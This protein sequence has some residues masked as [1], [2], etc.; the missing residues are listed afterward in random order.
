[1]SVKA[2]RVQ[3]IKPFNQAD[4]VVTW[5]ELGEVLRNVRYAASKIAN[6]AIQRLYSWEGFSQRYKEENGSYPVTKEHH[7]EWY[8]NYWYTEARRLF[9][10]VAAQ[11]INQ[12][13]RH[14]EKVW[15]SRKSEVLKLRQSVPSFK[16]DFPIC[17]HNKDGYSVKKIDNN[18]IVA[19]TLLSREHERS[20][21]SFIVKAGERSKQVIL[22]R[23]I[24]G[25]YKRGAMQIISDRKK[26][27]YCIIPY[28]FTPECDVKLDETKIMGVDLGIANAAYW[29]FSDSFKRGKIEGKEIEVFRKRI[30]ERRKSIQNQGK[31]C[32]DGRIGHGRKRRLE[33]IEVLQN[34]E[35]NFRA[36]TNHR[37]SR[38]I[39]E[40]AVRNNCGMI[41][42]EDLTSVNE[43]S[44]FLKNW[45]YYDL[46]QKIAEKAEEFNIRVVKINPEYTS[47]RCSKCG[48]IDKY[49]R[50]DQ[51]T[52]VC[53][54]CGYGSLYHCFN[55][56]KD[57]L[58]SG[59]C[60]ECDGDVKLI[61][62]HADY[63]AAKNIATPGIEKIIKKNLAKK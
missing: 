25:E 32:G 4:E 58:S 16:L 53:Q 24:S 57:Q 50:V 37:Y 12:I 26:K 30:Q 54:S 20:R 60:K 29:A 10:F 55:C 7:G 18:Y 40:V 13:G 56:G 11:T 59:K 23:V 14:A 61:P 31:F 22:D 45:T 8:S 1:M 5:E 43:N 9:P 49:N 38:R 6:F 36:T 3:I 19:A 33:P 27:W 51:A 34:K 63:N 42:M 17:F 41:Q 62:V 35:A 47:Q 21:F 2:L 39:V 52:F 15:K 46:Q 28:E 44:K 48:F